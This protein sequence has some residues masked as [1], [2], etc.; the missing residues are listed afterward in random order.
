M[1]M[2][3][4]VVPDAAP[5]SLVAAI[6]LIAATPGYADV[7][8][9]LQERLD[10]GRL[11][12]VPTLEDRAQAGLTGVLS[13][14]PEALQGSVLSLAATLV[15]EHY[16]LCRQ[17]HFGK[18]LSFWKGVVTRRPVM[19]DY[20][21]PAYQAQGEFLQAVAAS[22]PDHADEALEEQSLVAQSFDSN[23]A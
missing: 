18:T 1:A 19:R 12:F 7:A 5:A 11:R 6:A 17:S 14:G 16:H 3:D 9:D 4:Q 2:P 20:E 15:H 8:A 21:A 10:R 22:F 13:L 23:Y